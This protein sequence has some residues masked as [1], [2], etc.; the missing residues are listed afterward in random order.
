MHR[1]TEEVVIVTADMSISFALHFYLPLSPLIAMFS[2][3]HYLDL[4]REAL[5]PCVHHSTS[6]YIGVV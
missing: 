3:S 1:G 4:E 5:L 2:M 6:R